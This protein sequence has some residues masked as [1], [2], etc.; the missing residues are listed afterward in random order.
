M[1]SMDVLDA[2][3]AVVEA[4]PK[5]GMPVE[6]V[7]DPSSHNGFRHALVEQIYGNGSGKIPFGLSVLF[8]ATRLPPAI[9][10]TKNRTGKNCSI[11]IM[12]VRQ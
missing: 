5:A 7:Q 4:V 2:Y 9:A 3:M 1:V 11:T 12:L 6:Q 10:D 8:K